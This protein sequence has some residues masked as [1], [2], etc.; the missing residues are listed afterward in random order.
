MDEETKLEIR[1]LARVWLKHESFITMCHVS[2]VYAQDW[3]A[4]ADGGEPGDEWVWDVL[5]MYLFRHEVA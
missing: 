1:K 3:Q 4:V 2:G 5:R